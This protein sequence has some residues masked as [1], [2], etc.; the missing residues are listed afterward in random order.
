VLGVLI[1]FV[2]VPLCSLDDGTWDL[3]FNFRGLEYLE[4]TLGEPNII[5][6]NFLALM[7]TGGH[8]IIDSMYYAKVQGVWQGWT[9]PSHMTT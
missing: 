9:L 1:C 2:F 6:R 8:G 5:Y 7:E 4:R 3:R